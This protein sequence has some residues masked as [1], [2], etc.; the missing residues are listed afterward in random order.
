M[1]RLVAGSGFTPLLDFSKDEKR[2]IWKLINDELYKPHRNVW[3]EW[4][5]KPLVVAWEIA[6]C[7]E[8]GG[9]WI[10]R[11]RVQPSTP[12]ESFS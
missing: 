11:N 8:V 7:Q 6:Q 12:V 10:M 3:F 5:G 9:D 4:E 1:V 2:A